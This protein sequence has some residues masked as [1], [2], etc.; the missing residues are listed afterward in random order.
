MEDKSVTYDPFGLFDKTASSPHGGDNTAFFQ[1]LTELDHVS[2][3]PEGLE[4]ALWERLCE[5]RY[6]VGCFIKL[7]F[8]HRCSKIA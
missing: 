4:E 1:A 2:H 3:M 8:C 7:Y 6:C 5:T